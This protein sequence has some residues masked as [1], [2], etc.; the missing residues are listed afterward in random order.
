MFHY[1]KEIGKYLK[2]LKQKDSLTKQEKQKKRHYTKILQE[3]EEFLKELKED[4]IRLKRYQY[5]NNKDLDYKR[6][7]EIENVFDKIDEDYY[8]PIKTKSAFN[9]N[10]IEYESR[11][12][13]DTNLSLKDYLNIIEHS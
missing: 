10:H 12:D 4:L 2:E 3:A 9:D 8:K 13:K 7:I 5:N 6:I 11:G 1:M